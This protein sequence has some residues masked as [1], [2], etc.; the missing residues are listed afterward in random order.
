MVTLRN[1]GT[2]VNTVVVRSVAQQFYV[3]ET[4]HCEHLLVVMVVVLC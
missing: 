4:Q 1:V 2:I 3:E